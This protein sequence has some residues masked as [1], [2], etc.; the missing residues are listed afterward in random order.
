M[1]L[2]LDLPPEILEG[3]F[4]GL[5]NADIKNLR[6]ACTHLSHVARLRLNRTF[7]S[8]N[9]QDVQ[10]LRDVAGHET[11]RHR[12]TEL[13]YEDTR[14]ST[15][16]ELDEDVYETSS[17]SDNRAVGQVPTWYKRKYQEIREELARRGLRRE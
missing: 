9:P 15:T 7:L 10:V 1:V 6:L 2:L 13:I 4:F 16:R 3:V 14:F 11:Y 12:I 5:S 8:L 17:D